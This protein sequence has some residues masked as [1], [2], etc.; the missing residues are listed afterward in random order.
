MVAVWGQRYR[1]YLVN[2]C[3]PTLLAPGNFPL[4]D[5]DDGHRLLIATTANDWLAIKDLPIMRKVSTYVTPTAIQ[6]PPPD[7]ATPPGSAPAIVHQNRYQKELVER[8]YRDR[9]YGSLLWPDL[10]YSDG[11]VASLLRHA[12]AGHKCVLGAALRQSEESVL[13]ELKDRNLIKGPAASLS[14]EAIVLPPR[15]VA[16]LAVRHL[17]PEITICEE[18]PS[19]QPFLT[20]HRYWRVPHRRGII[21]HSFLFAPF[22]MDYSSLDR[23]NTEC[24]DHDK[25]EDVYVASNFGRPSDVHIVCDSDEFSVISITPLSVNQ[26]VETPRRGRHWFWDSKTVRQ[27]GI[28]IA[29]LLNANARKYPLKLALFRCPIIWHADDL[30]EVWQRQER[31]SSA[32]I[33]AALG[34]KFKAAARGA[35]LDQF[36]CNP[37]RLLADLYMYYLGAPKTGFG[38]RIVGYVVIIVRA[39]TGHPGDLRRI[40]RSIERRLRSL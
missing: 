32:M 33:E 3:L 40:W 4:L 39:L 19:G 36:S 21:L 38:M 9:A 13:A 20:I 1:N 8:A 18:G 35:V 25:F 12:I 37:L 22:L 27:W 15:T 2:S 29:F 16:D 28:R 31:K 6:L 17:H 7:T 34:D 30:D 11:M 23:H 14:A 5:P 10:I 24:L 26:V